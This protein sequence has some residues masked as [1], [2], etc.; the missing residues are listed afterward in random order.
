[1]AN[2]IHITDQLR[3]CRFIEKFVLFSLVFS[4]RKKFSLIYWTVYLLFI[5]IYLYQSKKEEFRQS[6]KIRAVVIDRLESTGRRNH[7]F[8][9]QFQFTYNDSVYISAD[10]LY[11]TREKAVGEKLTLVFPKGEPENAVI[12]TF[13]S[14]WIVLPTLLVSI[15]IFFF[16]YAMIIIIK[17]KEGWTMF[18]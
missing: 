13:V 12:Y 8:Y 14:Y 15:M 9:P 11:W 1:M 18:R 16:I 17:W 10:K 7:Y 2:Q 3:Y 5:C 6:E 4:S